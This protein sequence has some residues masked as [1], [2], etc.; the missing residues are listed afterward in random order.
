M[1]VR[2]KRYFSGFSN[3][4]NIKPRGKLSGMII[5]K[6]KDIEHKINTIYQALAL[7]KH[8]HFSYLVCATMEN[9]RSSSS[10]SCT[11]DDDGVGHDTGPPDLIAL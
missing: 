11:K 5:I 7:Q 9:A 1:R 4:T 8:C 10:E 6:Y 3:R 2:P